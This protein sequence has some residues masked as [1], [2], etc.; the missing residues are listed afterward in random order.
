MMDESCRCVRKRL[1]LSD[2]KGKLW[3]K[4]E[5]K[6]KDCDVSWFSLN[7]RVSLLNKYFIEIKKVDTK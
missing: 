2:T 3:P 4:I 6:K 7:T 1:N 5:V